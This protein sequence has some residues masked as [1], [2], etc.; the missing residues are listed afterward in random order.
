MGRSGPYLGEDKMGV[1]VSVG[2]ARLGARRARRRSGWALA[3]QMESEEERVG[4]AFTVRR[5]V[6]VARRVPETT[7]VFMATMDTILMS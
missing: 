6:V 1:G 5:M 2:G 4:L 3:Y 7:P